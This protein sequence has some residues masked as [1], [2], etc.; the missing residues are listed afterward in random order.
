MAKP[1]LPAAVCREGWPNDPDFPQLKIASD[2]GRMLAVFRQHLKPVAGKA[3]HIEECIPCR[4]RCRQ[5]TTRCVLQY[6]LRLIESVTGRELNVWVTGLLYVQPGEAER[7]YHEMQADQPGR[8]IPEDWRTLEPLAFIPDLQMLVQVFPYDRKL[9][10]LSLVL[11]GALGGL[12]PRLL[13]RLE[14][15]HWLVAERHLEPTRYRTELGAALR[16]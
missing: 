2:P 9:P 10:N 14:P 13:E 3:F 6:I 7:M 8:D 1:E 15:G 16:Y 5:S 4:F 12:E 11:G